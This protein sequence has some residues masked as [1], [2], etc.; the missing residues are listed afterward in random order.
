M[1]LHLGRDFSGCH[2]IAVFP[3]LDSGFRISPV[4][5]EE[6]L[7]GMQRFVKVGRKTGITRYHQVYTI[8]SQGLEDGTIPAG[9]ALPPETELMRVYRVGRNTIRRA[10]GRLE[11][12]QR[13]VRLRGSGTYARGQDEAQAAWKRLS[14]TVF[15]FERYAAET[16]A[17]YLK[18]LRTETP[19]AILRRIADFGARCLQIELTRS[20]EGKCFSV[21]VSHVAERVSAKLTQ[22]R[23]G[24]KV[25]LSVLKELGYPPASATQT[26][27][28]ISATA[29]TARLL[30]VASGAPLLVTE[31]LARDGHGLPLEHHQCVYRADL[32]PLQLQLRYDSSGS[33]FRWQAVPLS[34]P[35]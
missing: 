31:T 35:A 23:L 8:L 16:S 10:L 18:F 34:S 19:A 20:F 11:R 17:T 13:I 12:E 28:A 5:W 32:Y 33:G 25:I 22:K 3:P 29:E 14:S 21:N 15:D 9:S 24:D 4:E 27:R 26:T 7:S 30:D 1:A 2:S 6:R